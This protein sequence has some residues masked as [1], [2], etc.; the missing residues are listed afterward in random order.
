[1]GTQPRSP[2]KIVGGKA[3]SAE[4]IIAAFPPPHC[5][6]R[7]CE[8]FLGAAHVLFAKPASGHEEI[9]NDLS[10]NLYTFFNQLRDNAEIL[11]ERVDNLLY[12]RAQY[13]AFYASLFDGTKL[14]PLERA[15]RFFYCLRLTGTGWLRKSP[16]GVN[17]RHSNVLSFRSAT[18]VFQFA[19]ERLRYVF[20]DN[21]DALATIT[22]YD[23]PRTLIYADPPYID[24]EHYYEASRDGFDHVGLARVLN[25]AKGYVAL[26][27]YPHAQL[28]QLY[29]APK[30]RRMTWQQKKNCALY[31]NTSNDIGTEL[32]LMN[33]PETFGGLFDE[34]NGL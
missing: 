12:S 18:E 14:D 13:Y 6:D 22:R 7:Y 21:R 20:V 34:R 32:L 10:N 1:M 17:C 8:P 27:Y 25:Q 3:A 11:Q 28:D 33:Y 2:L 9:G 30:W 23:S 4:R 26:S 29:P 15:V 19:K 24:A 16:P 31:E 5:Y